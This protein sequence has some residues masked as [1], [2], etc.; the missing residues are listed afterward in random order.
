MT[1]ITLTNPERATQAGAWAVENIGYK[2]WTMD[3]QHIFSKTPRY[4]FKFKHKQDAVRFAL[5][6]I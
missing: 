5:Q 6:W 3:I 4:D 1:T 2:Y